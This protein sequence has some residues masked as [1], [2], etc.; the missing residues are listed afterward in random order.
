MLPAHFPP[1]FSG[2]PFTA[3]QVGNKL[4]W[5]LAAGEIR[6]LLQGVYVDAQVPETVALRAAG[7]ALLARPGKT[8]YGQTAAW[9][10]GIETTA[11]NSDS[12]DRV[13]LQWTDTAT[14]VVEIAGLSVTSPLATALHLAKHL[15]RPFALSAVD[16]ILRSGLVKLQQLQTAVEGHPDVAGIHQARQ[17]V[18]HADPRAESP[19]ESWLRLRLRDA[20]FGRPTLQIPV[21]GP[22]RNYRIDMGYPDHVDNGRRLGLE[23]DSDRWHSRPRQE[24]RDEHRR[25]EL[26]SFGWHIISV[27]RPDLWGHYPALELAVGAFLSTWPRLPRRW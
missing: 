3:R 27:R 11:L 1:F 25:T 17:I 13:P 7:V 22:N 18:S 19:G 16:A 21:Q 14:D 26:E 12:A 2:L 20:G 24:T 8:A 6:Q 15:P 4:T 5:L 10:H 23:Y 9:I